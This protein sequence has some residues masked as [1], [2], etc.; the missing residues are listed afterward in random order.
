MNTKRKNSFWKLFSKKH[1]TSPTPS[2]STSSA[3]I[4][5]LQAPHFPW[6]EWYEDF[7]H[8]EE[9]PKLLGNFYAPAWFNSQENSDLI[10]EFPIS[11]NRI[12]VLR[13][14]LC[15]HS[16]V[17]EAMLKNGM[18]ETSQ[19]VITMEEDDSRSE[20]AFITMIRFMY[21]AT[22][23][24]HAQLLFKLLEIAVKYQVEALQ[25]ACISY[26][27]L[28]IGPNNCY[29]LHTFALHDL[30]DLVPSES[31]RLE[32]ATTHYIRFHFEKTIE[33]SQFL[34]LSL[35]ELQTF[36]HR[37]DLLL[38]SE[39][40]AFQAVVNWYQFDMTRRRPLL[41]EGLRFVRLSEV[42]PKLVQ[43]FKIRHL[44]LTSDPKLL[45]L[46]FDSAV[47]YLNHAVTRGAHGLQLGLVN[48]IDYISHPGRPDVIDFT[49][50]TSVLLYGVSFLCRKGN[51]SFLFQLKQGNKVLAEKRT[52]VAGVSVVKLMLEEYVILAPETT[53]TL[54][55]ECINTS[56]DHM[57]PI[58]KGEKE[59]KGIG[60][61][62]FQFYD[63]S[64]MISGSWVQA[65]RFCKLFYHLNQ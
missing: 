39:D 24:C 48:A 5:E 34:N 65:N 13:A 45:D 8:F 56:F 46:F 26:M 55:L 36:L 59:V 28:Q 3:V 58:V 9:D 42:D 54:F 22:I 16:K 10:L 62:K 35:Q 6:I 44:D 61:C 23:D 40:V 63:S 4:T 11:N 14:V 1:K 38:R 27:I 31:V 29:Q 52:T 33:S 47:Q 20:E 37:P 43:A 18:Q 2:Y 32:Q 49:V 30:K 25:H 64:R 7:V 17:L 21:S 51:S 50:S 41:E 57:G 15:G 53:Y 12:H 19:R 60:G